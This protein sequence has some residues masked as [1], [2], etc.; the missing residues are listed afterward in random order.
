MQGKPETMRV[1]TPTRCCDTPRHLLNHHPRIVISQVAVL[2]IFHY[3][4]WL[5]KFKDGRLLWS[6]KQ[7]LPEVVLLLAPS[8]YVITRLS[9][10]LGTKRATG[11]LYWNFSIYSRSLYIYEPRVQTYSKSFSLSSNVSFLEHREVYDL[12]FLAW[13]T[14][15]VAFLPK[16]GTGGHTFWRRWSW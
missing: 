3:G 11:P 14:A 12:Q 10:S 15:N 2:S 6:L 7:N 8:Y 1:Y 9:V 13:R 5:W 16:P 4:T